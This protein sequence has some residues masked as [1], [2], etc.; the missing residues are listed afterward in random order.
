MGLSSPQVDQSEQK[1][2]KENINNCYKH[3]LVPKEVL[4]QKSNM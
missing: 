2:L 1:I 3:L 4:S